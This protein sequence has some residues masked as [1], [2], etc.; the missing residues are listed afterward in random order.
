[1]CLRRSDYTGCDLTSQRLGAIRRRS[2]APAVT[3]IKVSTDRRAAPTAFRRY[4]SSAPAKA[5]GAAPAPCS[6]GRAAGGQ[7][8]RRRAGS[9]G[10][11]GRLQISLQGSHSY[12]PTRWGSATD[13]AALVSCLPA[14]RGQA[15]GQC[16]RTPKQPRQ[17]TI[18]RLTA[19]RRRTR[20]GARVSPAGRAG[21]G[22]GAQLLMQRSLRQIRECRV[23]DAWPK[24]FTR[25]PF[26]SC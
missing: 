14:G 19:R 18:A 7:V 20:R 23:H 16:P 2:P 10:K 8:C 22:S 5:R 24:I 1:M 15:A 4:K 17:P 6:P 11:V 26:S 13:P 21:G 25:D 3:P 12:W 9:W